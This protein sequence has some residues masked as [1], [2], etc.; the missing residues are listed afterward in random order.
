[1]LM[2]A[3]EALLPFDLAATHVLP[4]LKADGAGFV[5]SVPPGGDGITGNA[6]VSTPLHESKRE[7]PSGKTA[8]RLTSSCE[9]GASLG[10][11]ASALR[12]SGRQGGQSSS[13]RRLCLASLPLT[14]AQATPNT[15]ARPVQ[16]V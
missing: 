3:H 7:R 14:S 8:S 4:W 16:M 1:M 12:P 15:G 5:G 10:R 11:Y 6:T 9:S 2:L 13:L